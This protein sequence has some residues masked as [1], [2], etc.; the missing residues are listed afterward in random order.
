MQ[1][2]AT[3]CLGE[4][5]KRARKEPDAKGRLLFLII[6]WVRNARKGTFIEQKAG[7]GCLGLGMGEGVSQNQREEN[8]WARGNV[9]KLRFGN[10]RQCHRL[11]AKN[12]GSAL[13]DG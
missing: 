9:L 12:R 4:P 6:S 5:Q 7:G 11:T 13:D 10:G 8:R 2:P 1:V 3:V